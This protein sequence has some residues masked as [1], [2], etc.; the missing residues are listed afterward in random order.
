M[1]ALSKEE[2]RQ[3]GRRSKVIGPLKAGFF[4]ALRPQVG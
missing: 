4:I 3:I 2:K 1:A